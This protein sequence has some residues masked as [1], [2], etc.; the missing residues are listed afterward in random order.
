M[1]LPTPLARGSR[2]IVALVLGTAVFLSTL[3]IAASWSI[4]SE[5]RDRDDDHGKH[6]STYSFG[7][8]DDFVSANG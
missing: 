4:R 7:T 1:T 8:D 6:G 2:G 3:L 5:A